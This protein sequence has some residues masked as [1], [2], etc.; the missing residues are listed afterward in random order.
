MALQQLRKLARRSAWLPAVHGM[1]ARGPRV[2]CLHHKAWWRAL[3]FTARQGMVRRATSAHA[4]RAL[5][6]ALPKALRAHRPHASPKWRQARTQYGDRMLTPSDEW[7]WQASS[8]R[9]DCGRA[10]GWAA[11]PHAC[12]H[13]APR[14]PWRACPAPSASRSRSPA[15]RRAARPRAA[16][17]GWAAGRGGGLARQGRLHVPSLRPFSWL[18]SALTILLQ[19]CNRTLY[20]EWLTLIVSSAAY[21]GLA[22]VQPGDSERSRN[23]CS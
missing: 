19:F 3:S 11:A 12:C 4:V 8:S 21:G 22:K 18:H 17:G 5:C 14:R 6:G 2:H 1:L 16:R 10:A 20:I 23:W 7:M 9:L 13:S 15:A